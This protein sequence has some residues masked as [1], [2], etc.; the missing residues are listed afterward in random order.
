MTDR[1][2]GCP[3]D[4]GQ[5]PVLCGLMGFDED[6][7]MPRDPRGASMRKRALAVSTVDD[8]SVFEVA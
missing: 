5:R 2:D 8:P 1:N 6:A 7:N 4:F 3:Q